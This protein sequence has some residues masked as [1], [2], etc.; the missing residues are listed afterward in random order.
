MQFLARLC[1]LSNQSVQYS[2][3]Q[4]VSALLITNQLLT[5]TL[6]DTRIQSMINARKSNAPATLTRL[7]FLLRATTHGNAFVSTYGTNF[8][9]MIPSD[10]NAPDSFCDTQAVIYEN[11]CS[12]GL[13]T[14]CTIPANFVEKNSAKYV[15]INGLK[16]GCTPSESF[17]VSTLECFYNSSCIHLI[18]EMT[19]YNNNNTDITNVPNPLDATLSKFPVNITVIDLVDQLFVERWSTIMNYSS[20][21]ELCA[22]ML[23]SYAYR[24]ELASFY[25]VTY[26]IGL[27]GGLTILLKWICPRIIS[28]IAKIYQHRKKRTNVVTSV[29]SA[30]SIITDN[31]DHIITNSADTYHA[32]VQLE[33]IS[34]MSTYPYNFLYLIQIVIVNELSFPRMIPFWTSLCYF[35]MGLVLFVLA[36]VLLLVPT[37]YYI[38]QNSNHPTGKVR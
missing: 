20:Y 6:F 26:L 4:S 17:L 34:T 5:E 11:N 3:Q 7:L 19:N 16:M 8:Q 15:T 28:L 13:N 21:F 12:C 35:G 22:P 31:S 29:S 23:C 24:Q 14:T 2:I 33:P 37:V 30:A 18:H 25:T 9:Y 38:R 27:Y 1:Q 36:A 10:T 32:P